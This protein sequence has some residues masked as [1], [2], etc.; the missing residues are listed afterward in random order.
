MKL[1]KYVSLAAI[2]LAVVTGNLLAAKQVQKV[3]TIP[4]EY[5]ATVQTS[6]CMAA[7][8]PQVNISGDLNP[9]GLE[10]EII[11]SQP[12]KVD[13]FTSGQEVVPQNTPIPLTQQQ[14]VGGLGDNPFLWLQ[15]VDSKGR[16][17]SSEIFLGQCSQGTFNASASLLVPLD[18]TAE[19]TT[20]A[21][22]T[23]RPEV[24]VINGSAEFSP[25][26][27][28]LILRSTTEVH[29]GQKNEVTLDLVLLPTGQEYAFPQ[30]IVQG[31]I[32]ANPQIS[33]QFREGGG[34]PVGNQINF[35]RCSTLSN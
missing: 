25:I 33:L 22:A 9:A 15:L 2:V 21:C 28:R 1:V 3:V 35:G 23:S 14:V 12:G 10:A 27:G 6:N 24:Q 20:D 26:N 7:Q 34:S 19:I 16:P 30:P 5:T 17:M 32:S 4:A 31:Q 8:G 13:E 11:F 18:T 29:G